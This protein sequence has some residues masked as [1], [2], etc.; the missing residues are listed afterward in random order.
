MLLKQIKMIMKE[1]SF[2]KQGKTSDESVP[3]TPDVVSIASIGKSSYA[4]AMKDLA[5]SVVGV[6]EEF[7]VHMNWVR[8]INVLL[9]VTSK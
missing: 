6:N 8:L 1:K 9:K 4:S 2:P 5:V 3:A 7:F